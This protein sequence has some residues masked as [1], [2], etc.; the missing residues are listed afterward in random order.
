MSES[1][2]LNRREFL[3]RSACASLALMALP[4]FGE[5]IAASIPHQEGHFVH[6]GR[7]IDVQSWHDLVLPTSQVGPDAPTFDIYVFHDPLYKQP[8]V[9]G[10]DLTKIKAETVYHIY[11]DRWPVE[12][13]PL[14]A[15]QMIG[16]YSGPRNLD[17]ENG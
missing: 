4:A 17:T 1:K 13:P 6:E 10:T 2:P 15:K 5:T 14:A 7:R 3:Q 11:R 8:L 16:L 9:L 12:Q